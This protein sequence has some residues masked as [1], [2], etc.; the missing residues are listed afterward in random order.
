MYF[1]MKEKINEEETGTI[2]FPASL[3]EGVIL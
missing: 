2:D 3:L 1:I